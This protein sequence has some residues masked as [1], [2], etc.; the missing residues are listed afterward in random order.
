V[1]H[2]VEH[3]TGY[4]DKA[5]GPRYWHGF[6][7][8]KWLPVTLSR[9]FGV[10]LSIKGDPTGGPPRVS[11]NVLRDGVYE[12]V[13][14]GGIETE[15]DENWYPRSLTAHVHTAARTY[16]VR[17]VARATVPLR[18]RRAGSESYTRITETMAEYTC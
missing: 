17:G 6:Y 8:Y 13:T 11:G 1:R 4:R 3:G 10:L 7:W 9:D 15:Y 12:P 18:H 5:W 2:A 16:V 14:G